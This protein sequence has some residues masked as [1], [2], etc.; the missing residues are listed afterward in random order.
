MGRIEEYD[1]KSRPPFFVASD[2]EFFQHLGSDEGIPHGARQY[3]HVCILSPDI[4]LL[5]ARKSQTGRFTACPPATGK[6][7]KPGC[8]K[9]LSAHGQKCR[10]RDPDT[11][12]HLHALL[13]AGRLYLLYRTAHKQALP[14]SHSHRR[15]FRFCVPVLLPAQFPVFLH[16]Q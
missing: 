15:F 12:S 11:L 13:Y 6:N 3:P 16:L 8:G 14:F 2:P 4:F 9:H 7:G 10:P 1:Q 5:P